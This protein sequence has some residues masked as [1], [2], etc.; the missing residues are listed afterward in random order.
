MGIIIYLIVLFFAVLG[1][2]DLIHTLKLWL[3]GGKRGKIAL[4]C[5]ISDAESER[6]LRFAIEQLKWH[7]ERYIGEVVAVTLTKNEE[8]LERC[9]QLGDPLGVRF[10]SPEEPADKIICG[11]IDADEC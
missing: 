8:L 9:H 6:S 2:C 3:I 1:L 10:M 4:C 7:G 5:L 11:E